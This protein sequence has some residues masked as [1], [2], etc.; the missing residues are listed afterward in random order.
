MTNIAITGGIASGKSLLGKLLSELG[1]DVLDV[2]EIIR[3]MHGPDGEGAK[4]VK[5]VFGSDYLTDNGGTNRMKLGNFVFNN[6]AALK[7][8]NDLMHPIA[9]Q[10]ALK[11][12][13]A[14]SPA[15]FKAALIPL[16]FE[17]GW[18][19]DWDAALAIESPLEARISRLAARGLSQAEALA[20]V[21]AQLP[22]RQRR[23][24]ADF[25]I[26]NDGG[27]PELKRAAKHIFK[28]MEKTIK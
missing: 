19:A 5:S 6:P 8:L 9:R 22:A 14:A 27:I 4:M 11:W 2:D 26:L 25:V 21:N 24:Q 1:A 17:S 15:P 3:S 12:R 13:D 10:A 28:C 23:E 16:L 18:R 20:R 7:R